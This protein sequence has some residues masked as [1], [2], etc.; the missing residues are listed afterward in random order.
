MFT[1][2]RETNKDCLSNDPIWREQFHI[3]FSPVFWEVLIMLALTA[4]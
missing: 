4:L 1:S 2:N 3:F